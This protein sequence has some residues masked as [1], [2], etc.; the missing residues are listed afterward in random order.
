MRKTKTRLSINPIGYVKNDVRDIKFQSWKDLVSRL[1]IK[2]RYVEAMEGLEEF[3]HL[4]IISWL[5]LPGKLL[6]KRH[7]RDRQDLPEV[8]IFATRS[9]MRP[10]RLGLH[11][12]QL[13]RRE[14]NELMVTG[15]DAVDGTPLIDIKPYIPQQ[16]VLAGVTV[17]DWVRKLTTR[18]KKKGKGT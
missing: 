15:L 18:E 4:F 1:V 2:H 16:D 7:P 17:P 9:Q 5:H 13:L 11:L 10:N 6:L 14:G 8:G 3:S 12:V